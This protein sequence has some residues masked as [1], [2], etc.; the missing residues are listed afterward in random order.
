MNRLLNQDPPS[1]FLHFLILAS[2]LFSYLPRKK[3]ICTVCGRI[4]LDND[5]DEGA[6]LP[7]GLPL[8]LIGQPKGAGS[9]RPRHPTVDERREDET[10]ESSDDST[11]PLPH[12]KEEEKE[13]EQKKKKEDDNES[14][15]KKQR[16]GEDVATVG[17][18]EPSPSGQ[19]VPSIKYIALK[20]DEILW[21]LKLEKTRAL[22]K[23]IATFINETL[24]KIQTHASV[25]LDE[26]DLHELNDD[27]LYFF[28]LP[29]QSW[30]DFKAYLVGILQKDKEQN[31]IDTFCAKKGHGAAL[32][33]YYDIHGFLEA[34]S[35]SVVFWFRIGARF[36]GNQRDELNATVQIMISLHERK[37][38]ATWLDILARR[39]DYFE[40]NLLPTLDGSTRAD[41]A[42]LLEVMK[43]S[44]RRPPHLY[45]MR[46]RPK[47]ERMA[48]SVKYFA[49]NLGEVAQLT[50]KKRHSRIF[51]NDV[52]RVIEEKLCDLLNVSTIEKQSLV[53]YFDAVPRAFS[54]LEDH[55]VGVLGMLPE[56]DHIFAF[57]AKKGHEAALIKFFNIHGSLQAVSNVAMFWFHVGARFLKGGHV[58]NNLV[59]SMA[60]RYGNRV[61]GHWLDLFATMF[62]KYHHMVAAL[63]TDDANALIAQDARKFFTTMRKFHYNEPGLYTMELYPREMHRADAA[64]A[65]KEH[66]QP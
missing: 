7:P 24:C 57:C 54:D 63:R 16:K 27:F 39:W 42:A 1:Y 49:F 31:H 35:S 33:D 48:T 28:S 4:D 40:E 65:Q 29:P 51:I 14:A 12:E 56:T 36:V 50:N 52:L 9:K 46:L 66:Q 32:I 26:D 23:S 61:V 20:L 34:E 47:S 6:P 8:Q 15:T 25:L 2:H 45:Y 38:V 41:A 22:S 58:V 55:L 64:T 43:R 30:Q 53:Y 3:M 60:R 59:K 13:E 44:Y 11:E 19:L 37:T 17:E 18:A 62:E 10:A 21:L 5:H